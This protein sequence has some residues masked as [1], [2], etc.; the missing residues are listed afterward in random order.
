MI[1]RCVFIFLA[2]IGVQGCG[3]G[4]A[5]P[6]AVGNIVQYQS[7]TLLVDGAKVQVTGPLGVVDLGVPNWQGDYA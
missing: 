6:T 1:R 7:E 5:S 2:A 4:A 3:G